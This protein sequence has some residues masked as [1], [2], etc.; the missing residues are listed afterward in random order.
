MKPISRRGF[1]RSA[2][3]GALTA[4]SAGVFGQYS[5]QWLECNE[6]TFQ[7]KRWTR[8]G[9]RVAFLSDTHLVDDNAVAVTRQAVDYAIGARPNLIVFGGD[10]VESSRGGSIDRMEA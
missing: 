2:G 7:L 4:A 9:F 5:T 1:L 8:H 6:H 10:F 3:M